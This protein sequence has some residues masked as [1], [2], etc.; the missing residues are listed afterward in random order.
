MQ[1]ENPRSDEH[2][3]LVVEGETRGF[4]HGR[5]MGRCGDSVGMLQCGGHRHGG[6][7]GHQVRESKMTTVGAGSSNHVP[8]GVTVWG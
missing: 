4:E 7:S 2:A 1:T 8:D 3:A 5:V 6:G